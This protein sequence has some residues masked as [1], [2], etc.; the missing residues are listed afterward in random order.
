MEQVRDDGYAIWTVHESVHL[1]G[2]GLYGHINAV[3]GFI[4]EVLGVKHYMPGASFV[5]GPRGTLRSIGKVRL[6]SNPA[7]PTRA[8]GLA[9]PLAKDWCIVN[10]L[11]N[12][13]DPRPYVASSH[14]HIGF[15]FMRE[16]LLR[17]H[18]EYYALRDGKRDVP[19]PSAG[20]RYEHLLLA[21]VAQPCFS[22][23][24]V[25][26]EATRAA[27]A[28]FDANP[29]HHT[30]SL[31][32]N[33]TEKYCECESCA[34]LNAAGADQT[35]RLIS[36][37]RRYMLEQGHAAG[38]N[39]NVYFAF[40]N[41][42]AKR[43]KVS[44]PGKFLGCLAYES[45]EEPPTNIERLE[46]NVCVCLTQDSSQYFDDA[47]RRR[48]V[49]ILEAWRAK[50]SHV[51]KYDYYGLMWY[52]PRY[53]PHTVAADIKHQADQG[54]VGMY[55]EVHPIWPFTGPMLYLGARLLW[56]ATLDV[57]HVLDTFF[58]DLYGDAAAEVKAF[59]DLYEE[60]WNRPRTGQWF[61]GLLFPPQLEQ[62]P[63]DK[64][65]EAHDHLILA[66]RKLGD[67]VE[68]ERVEVLLRYHRFPLE[69]STAEA[70]SRRADSAEVASEAFT[71]AGASLRALHALESLRESILADP[72]AEASLWTGF[73]YDAMYH[74]LAH[75]VRNRLSSTLRPRI[76]GLSEH[77]V[78]AL[79]ELLDD[80]AMSIGLWLD[81]LEIEGKAEVRIIGFDQDWSVAHE[82]EKLGV[83]PVSIA[84]AHDGMTLKGAGTVRLA[85]RTPV[86]PRHAYGATV[87]ADTDGVCILSE[88][89]LSLEWLDNEESTIGR[90]WVRF[91][92][93]KG[94]IVLSAAGQAPWHAHG[95][96]VVLSFATHL[97]EE[98]FT[99]GPLRWRKALAPLEI[100]VT[101]EGE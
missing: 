72:T 25:I 86:E 95:A 3:A 64:V 98:G 65:V 47:Y 70:M 12:K 57:A 62:F 66:S 33:D 23:P 89:D 51:M 17:E 29:E 56:N 82:E 49:D 50:C 96:R 54:L 26:E 71:L 69:I 91:G 10:R 73:R 11:F 55:A 59:Y 39:S 8:Y 35:P 1:A 40:V 24:G 4:D 6:I 99:L 19:Q 5:H 44:H 97:P 7:F 83:A 18:P 85:W 42:V 75:R 43:L 30:F 37:R 87:S 32:V 52:F 101:T 74:Y 77:Q 34:A 41:E 93:S 84:Q 22:H 79:L 67:G 31:G 76:Q 100:T 88:F 13:Q 21:F 60:L 61:Q 15:I 9:N 36:N 94:H 81:R 27:R 68:R 90:T 20:G 53:Y 63:H 78:R 2:N 14:H 38:R 28:Y 45:V 16:D 46:D 48:D 80:D 92:E 58:R